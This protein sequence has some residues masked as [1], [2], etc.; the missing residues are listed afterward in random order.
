MVGLP[1]LPQLDMVPTGRSVKRGTHGSC[2]SGHPGSLAPGLPRL[3]GK[4][5][6]LP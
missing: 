3:A 5:S 2:V 6:I 4:R 1:K